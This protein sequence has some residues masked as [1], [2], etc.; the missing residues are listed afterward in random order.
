MEK[1]TTSF[2]TNISYNYVNKNQDLTARAVTNAKEERMPMARDLSTV[3]TITQLAGVLQCTDTVT[4]VLKTCRCGWVDKA[5]DRVQ[6]CT[7]V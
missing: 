3:T 6:V 5:R 1:D 7:F 4:L 2:N